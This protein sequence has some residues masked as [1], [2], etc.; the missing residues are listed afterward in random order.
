MTTKD[1]GSESA[2]LLR[3]SGLNLVGGALQSAGGFLAIVLLERLLPSVTAL[4]AF[5]TGVAAINLAAQLGQL[6]TGTGL[7]RFLATSRESRTHVDA[8][9]VARVGLLPAL[10]AST[11]LGALLWIFADALAPLMADDGAAETVAN[12]LR[13]FAPLVPVLALLMSGA[14]GTRAFETMAPA[15]LHVNVLRP[16]LQILALTCLWVFG[17]SSLP[18]VST[19]YWLPT[20]VAAI[21][22]LLAL[23][24]LLDEDEASTSRP[25][26]DRSLVAAYWRFTTPR[27]VGSLF[28]AV[29]EWGDALLIAGLSST[30]D[31]GIYAAST[32]FLVVGRTVQ[33]AAVNALRPQINRLLDAGTM[34]EAQE[35]YRL[36]ATWSV[37][38]AWPWFLGIA[39]F[40][41]ELL[42]LLT[43]DFVVAAPAVRI[44]C[45][46]WLLGT[47]LGPVS[48]VLE[49]AGKST[50][51]MLDLGLAMV[52]NLCLNVVLIPRF[53]LTG[54]AIAWTSSIAVN[55]VLPAWQVARTTGMRPLGLTTRRVAAVAVGTAATLWGADAAIAGSDGSPAFVVGALLAAGVIYVL[56]LAR[57]VPSLDLRRLVDTVRSGADA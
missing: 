1:R 43:A 22:I 34:D 13:W 40:A 39:V 38:L 46:G 45:L 24:R 44:L 31:A 54:A 10:L 7:V 36:A 57:V 30:A 3:G 32:R 19:A 18:L 28:A 21:G 48:A 4:G 9:R 51:S 56:V 52:V 47:A 23:R 17:A 25:S 41:E 53:G 33:L 55:N 14:E 5:L 29:V 26:L 50:W 27:A 35:T 8:R 11:A 15:V 20:V 12:Y 2:L 42:G 6:G 37:T 16:G 49:M